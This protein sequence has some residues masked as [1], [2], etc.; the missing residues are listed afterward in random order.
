MSSKQ[1]SK[2]YTISVVVPVYNAE[3]YL[4]Q[5]VDSIIN[6]AYD[7][8]KI[9]VLLINDGSS[10]NS[11]SICEEYEKQYENITLMNQKNQGV[12]VA[13]NLGIKNAKGKYIMLL[14]SDDFISENAICNIVSF[15]EKNED[16]IDL[17]TYP[18]YR[19]FNGRSNKHSRYNRYDKG[20]GIYNLEEYIHLNQNT[21][22]V[23]VKNLGKNS[24][25]YDETMKLSEDQNFNTEILMKKKKIGYVDTAI[26]YYRRAG[27]GASS[28]KNNPYYCFQDIMKYNEGLLT[29]YVENKKIPKYVQ[30]L[31]LHTMNWRLN[32]DELFPYFYEPKK[33][34]DAK[35]RIY[36]IIKKIDIDVITSSTTLSVYNKIYF[37]EIS[38]RKLSL[39]FEEGYL[40]VNCQEHLVYENDKVCAEIIKL[41]NKRNNLNIYACLMTPFFDFTNLSLYLRKTMKDRTTKEEKVNLIPS[42][43]LMKKCQEFKA[44]TYNIN[45]NIDSNKVKKITMY[46][47]IKDMEA[48]IEWG[49]NNYTAANV[50]QDKKAII[51]KKKRNNYYLKIKKATILQKILLAVKNDLACLGKNYVAFLY[52]ILSRVYI[53]TNPIYLYSDRNNII[54]NAYYQFKHDIKKHDKITRYYITTMNEQEQNQ[55]FSKQEQKHLIKTGS[56]K[57]KLLFLKCAKIFTSFVD[58]Q[59][60]CPFNKGIK[61]YRNIKRYDLIYLQHGILHADL[62]SM[63]SKEFKEID[64]FVISSNFEEENLKNK[65]NYLEEDFIK[66]TMPRMATIKIDKTR[67]AKNKILFAPSWRK[68]LIGNLIKG[69]RDLITPVFKSSNFF[70]NTNEF[71]KSK[72]LNELLEKEDLVIE[73]KLHPNFRGYKNLF[74]TN[75]RIKISFDDVDLTEYKMFITDFS[76]FQFDYIKLQR[77]IIYFLPDESEFKAGMHTYK[78]LDL[79]YEDAF[80]PLCTNDKEL[81]ENIKKVIENKYKT[82]P[83]YKN[84]M[85]NFFFEVDNP[86]E[87]IYKETKK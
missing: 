33:Y 32:A 21:V 61:N 20:T 58:L 79:S 83:K 87:I 45:L 57:H 65:Y 3:N 5:C 47:K 75:D 59:I 77:P 60:Y 2:K 50:I 4:H 70:I 66:S 80:G 11:K 9:E 8:S 25:L 63:Y 78:S 84:R 49:F 73:F 68:Y 6:Q 30:S 86:C 14:D 7:F 34:E 44:H 41:K 35:Q 17:V 10:D 71:F 19:Y 53:K 56:L 29:K 26:Y 1:N 37:L 36:N 81:L 38:G 62:L 46:A 72:E 16:K 52:R 74:Y 55:N 76:S 28:T 82:T 43:R 85:K 15:F 12:S 31:V 64:K 67:P 27:V 18:I 69:Q 40:R 13:R 22:N 24:T 48:P 54:D 23:V 39:N 51:Y 42:N